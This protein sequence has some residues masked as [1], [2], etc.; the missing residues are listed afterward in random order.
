MCPYREYG[1]D[2]G[3]AQ[4]YAQISSMITAGWALGAM[5]GPPVSGALTQHLSFEWSVTISAFLH[6]ALVR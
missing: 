4:T 6:T 5:L 1:H 3:S 2:V